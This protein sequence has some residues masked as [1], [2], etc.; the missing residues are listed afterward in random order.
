MLQQKATDANQERKEEKPRAASG[1]LNASLGGFGVLASLGAQNF[2]LKPT[3][4]P[5]GKSPSRNEKSTMLIQI[6]GRRK[7]KSKIVDLSI[8]S[9]NHV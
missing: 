6:K 9:L 5:E 4:S 2:E 8:R 1:L 3:S 7:L